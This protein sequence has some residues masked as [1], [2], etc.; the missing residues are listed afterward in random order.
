[1]VYVQSAAPVA[2]MYGMKYAYRVLLLMT[3][4]IA[5]YL[6]LVIGSVDLSNF[7]MKSRAIVL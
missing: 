6:T 5:L 4:R 7:V 2:L 1:M 3:L